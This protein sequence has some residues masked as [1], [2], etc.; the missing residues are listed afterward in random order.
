MTLTLLGPAA[1]AS[2]AETLATANLPTADLAGPDQVF[3]RFEDEALVGY[4]GLEGDGPD[5]LLR[6][7]VIAAGRRGTGLGRAML[8]ALERRARELGVV[9]LHLLTDSAAP[10]FLANGYA[11][12]DRSAAPASI[13]G[14]AEF[15]TLCPASAAYLVKS[16]ERLS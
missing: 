6:S 14:S 2:L 15:R 4:G 13:A 1:L 3:F 9:R 10:F 12:A 16:L 5:R 7:F 8:A 11:A